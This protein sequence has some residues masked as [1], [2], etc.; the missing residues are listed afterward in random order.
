[1]KVVFIGNNYEF[2]VCGFS[3]QLSCIVDRYF[4]I[5]VKINDF[6]KIVFGFKCSDEVVDSV[7]YVIEIVCW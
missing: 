5:V 2:F 7:F 6:V 1:M 3:N 4:E